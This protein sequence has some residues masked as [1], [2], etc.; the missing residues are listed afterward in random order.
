MTQETNEKQGYLVAVKFAKGDTAYTYKT[1]IS[2]LM[3]GELVA[4]PQKNGLSMA[5]VVGTN[6]KPIPLT[7]D[8]VI[9]DTRESNVRVT[10]ITP[11]M[12]EDYKTIRE[13]MR[14]PSF[15]SIGIPATPSEADVYAVS[16]RFINENTA[17]QEYTYLT[18]DNTLRPGEI[19]IVPTGA[20][21]F[22]K[23][24]VVVDY[25]PFP[26]ETD[27]E[28]KKVYCRLRDYERMRA[29]NGV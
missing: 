26:Q 27:I 20:F 24:A 10:D 22:A 2:D 29:G 21:N 8:N 7:D 25:V 3:V 6:E 17:R 5:A 28:F 16:V 12:R 13:R 1:T 23:R 14:K 4:V 9:I 19:I 18:D 15:F 11:K